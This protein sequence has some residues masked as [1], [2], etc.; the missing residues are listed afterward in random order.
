MRK[1]FRK[2]EE[3]RKLKDRYN[4]IQTLLA[5]YCPIFYM[6]RNTP[7]SAEIGNRGRACIEEG[8]NTKYPCPKGFHDE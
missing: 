2:K 1:A 5:N 8:F 6:K 7:F 3:S 4:E